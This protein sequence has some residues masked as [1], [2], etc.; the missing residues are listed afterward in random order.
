VK[1]RNTSWKEFCNMTSSINPW[2]EIYRIAAGRRRQVAQITTLRKQEGTLT[3]NL[4]G[5]LIHML[6]NFRPK[7]NQNDDTEFHKQ[8]RALTQES[9]DRLMIRNSPF[10]KP[11]TRWQA[12]EI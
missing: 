10:R 3:T 9:I 5:T 6:R 11:R 12:W 8:L 1:E 2:N 4:H 7:D